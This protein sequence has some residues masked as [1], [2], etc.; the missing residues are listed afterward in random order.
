MLIRKNIVLLRLEK[1]NNKRPEMVFFK[2]LC[3]NF[4]KESDTMKKIIWVFGESAT[5]KL[6]L[7][8]NLYNGDTN[9]TETFNVN[10][11]KITVS[12]ITLEDRNHDKYISIM[13]INNY[14]DDLMEE[15]NLYFTKENALLRRKGI[16]Y[17][18][19]NFL[20]SDSDILLIKGQVNDLNIRRGNIVGN[21]LEKY[22][23]RNDVEIETLVLQVTDQEELKRRL[24]TKPWFKEMTDANEKER[25]LIEI[26]LEQEKHKELVIDGFSNYNIPI[27]IVESLNNGY[28]IENKINEKSTNTNMI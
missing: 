3:Y 5:G 20:N 8:N 10:D 9:T 17:D 18:T 7:I 24:E 28:K 16:M 13:D 23:N 21:F 4:Y 12:E 2:W 15:D 1:S 25:L 11:K 27:T 14:D 26:P 19:D 22:T 6:T